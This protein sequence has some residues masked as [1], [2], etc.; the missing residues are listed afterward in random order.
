MFPRA[1]TAR[2]LSAASQAHH[3]DARMH[4]RVDRQTNTPFASEPGMQLPH[5]VHQPEAG[6]DRPL[7]VIVMGARVAEVDHDPF[8][9]ILDDM[10]I[11]IPDDAGTRLLVGTEH[12]MEIF[13]VQGAGRRGSDDEVA[14][15]DRELTPFSVGGPGKGG[16]GGIRGG[17]SSGR[18]VSAA[19]AKR[20][21]GDGGAWSL[22]STGATKRYPCPRTV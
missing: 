1:P 21:G 19:G 18:S 3:D 13:R 2:A 17:G 4:P 6:A 7:G 15:H 12:G 10:A 5:R 8:P 16:G 11:K 20:R 14:K 22:T 9:T